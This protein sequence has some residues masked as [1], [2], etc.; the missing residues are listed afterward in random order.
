MLIVSIY[1]PFI[2]QLGVI[3][4][5][6]FLETSPQRSQQNV[7]SKSMDILLMERILHQ[8]IG[9]LSHYLQGFVH[10]RFNSSTPHTVW[11]H[12]ST[13]MLPWSSLKAAE[14]MPDLRWRPSTFWEM[15]CLV[16]SQQVWKE[17]EVPVWSNPCRLRTGFQTWAI[18][19]SL[20]ITKGSYNSLFR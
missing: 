6:W 20:Y 13:K 9:S 14:G 11:M 18:S 15:I 7:F 1:F 12:L 5:W 16:A 17:R 4:F 10:P 19:K 2:W 3:M 8:L